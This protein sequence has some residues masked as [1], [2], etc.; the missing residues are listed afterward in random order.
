M[1]LV[2]RVGRL[3]GR[4]PKYDPAT[5]PVFSQFKPWSGFA[6]AEFDVNFVGQ[7]TDVSFNAGWADAERMRDRETWPPYPPL[8]DETFEW[9]TLL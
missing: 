5:H 9:E 2:Q 3:L 6:P 7:R 4:A 8:S 1:N